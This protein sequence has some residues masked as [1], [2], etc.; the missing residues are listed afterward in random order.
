[1]I[2]IGFK[3][4]KFDSCLYM[5]EI[6]KAIFIYLVIYGDHMLVVCKEKAQIEKFKR[7][8]SLKF[9]MKDLGIAK[10]IFRMLI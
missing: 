8:M 5:K 9:E 10:W 1:M 6:N 7:L 2:S 3:R 4:S